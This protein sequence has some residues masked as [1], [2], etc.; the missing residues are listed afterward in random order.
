MLCSTQDV[1][2]FSPT[3]TTLRIV[4]AVAGGMGLDSANRV[5]LTFPMDD[6]AVKNDGDIAI[7]GVPV[8]AGRVPETA[9]ERLRQHVKGDGRPAVL[10]VV[11]GNRAFED[12]LLEL[13]DLAVELGFVPVAG[14]AFIGEHSYSTSEKPVAEGRPFDGDLEKARLFGVQVAEKI[15]HLESLDR[16][17]ALDVPGNF[18]YRDGVKPGDT[19]PVTD[20]DACTL[21][22]ECARV[23]PTQVVEITETDVQTHD[24]CIRCSAC[25]KACPEQAREW[26]VPRILE[27]RT[28]LNTTHAAPKEPETFL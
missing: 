12:A 20:A 4:D 18:P 24:G 14:G 3:K 19:T 11:Y 7:I 9:V 22:G 17:D 21:C 28:F 25:V 6:E 26:D 23:C 27:I 8:Y 1:I 2:F 10:V 16:M 15:R 5:D 13:R